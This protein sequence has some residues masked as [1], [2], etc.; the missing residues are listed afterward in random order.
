M[1]N[2]ARM[3]KIII[4]VVLFVAILACSNFVTV[5][6]Q[7]IDKQYLPASGGFF[8][9]AEKWR[10]IIETTDGIQKIEGLNVYYDLEIGDTVEYTYD[11][12]HNSLKTYYKK[13]R[14]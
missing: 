2:L 11:R 5:K 13:T 14:G 9:V 1:N 12:N 8:T 6:G 3:K 7:V 10:V 4:V